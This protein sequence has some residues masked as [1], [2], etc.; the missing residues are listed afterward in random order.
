MKDA[1]VVITTTETLADGQRLAN[2]LVEAG[3]AACVQILPQIASVYRW[4]GKVEQ[5]AETLLLIKTTRTVYPELE[6]AIKQNHSY[7]TPEIV[8][9][10]VETGSI[11]YLD[12]L[13]AS[14]GSVN[15]PPSSSQSLTSA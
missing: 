8:A 2:L 7:E 11:E 3:L 5:A 9:L 15:R 13:M 14:V 10:P 1:L 6:T 12:W 4:Q